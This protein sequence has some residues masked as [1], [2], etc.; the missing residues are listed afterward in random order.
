MASPD[1]RSAGTTDPF[2]LERFVRAQA[3]AYDDALAELRAGR[4][5]SHWIWFI[6]PQMLGLGRSPTSRFYAISGLAEAQAYLAHP[7]LGPRLLACVD[8]VLATAPGVAAE[9][10]FG[11]LDARKVQSSMTLF[12]RAAPDGERFPAMLER[13]HGGEPDAATDDALRG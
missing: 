10:I 9:D 5:E 2:D 4:K 11:E 1:A 6:F 8:A 13:F 3:D 12:A 7:I